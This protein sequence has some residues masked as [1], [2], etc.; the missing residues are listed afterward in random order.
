MAV[1]YCYSKA[2]S[3]AK[4]TDKRISENISDH[5]RTFQANADEHSANHTT[6]NTLT[7]DEMEGNYEQN[8]GRTYDEGNV[9]P[10][11]LEEIQKNEGH[12]QDN[13]A[14]NRDSVMHISDDEMPND[15]DTAGNDVNEEQ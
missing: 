7:L 15:H 11:G 10:E 3:T 8:N 1:V 5:E 2:H 6:D 14:T 9:L 4:V 12:D 13:G